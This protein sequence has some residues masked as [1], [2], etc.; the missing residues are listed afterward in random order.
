MFDYKAPCKNC[1]FRKG[2]GSLYGLHPS[3]LDEIKQ[4]PAFE[5]HKTAHSP[6]SPQQC[7]GVMVLHHKAGTPNQIMQLAQRLVGADFSKLDNHSLVYDDWD[8][9]FKAHVKGV[10]PCTSGTPRS[11]TAL[12]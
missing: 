5:C 7:V 2:Q 1:P 4:A 6:A 8:Q 10:E 9:A 11:S 12:T 3:R